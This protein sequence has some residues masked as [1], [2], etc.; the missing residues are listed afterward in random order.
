MWAIRRADV[1]LDRRVV[2]A[3]WQSQKQKSDQR[4]SLTAGTVD[5]LRL[6]WWPERELV[7]PWVRTPQERYYYLSRLLC[8]AGLPHTNR[9]KFGRLRR[10]TANLCAARGV[11]PTR[12]LGHSSP[13]V[14]RRYYLDDSAGPTA[15]DVLPDVE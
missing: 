1:D 10:T 11:D 7:F 4:L 2:L 9:D 14:T 12:Q 6:I 13:E 15:G 5:A 3:R 8:L